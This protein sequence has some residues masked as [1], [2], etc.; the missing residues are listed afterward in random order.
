VVFNYRLGI[1]A[2]EPGKVHKL[3]SAVTPPINGASTGNLDLDQETAAGIQI[4]L[5]IVSTEPM[6]EVTEGQVLF[7]HGDHLGSA[8]IVTDDQGQV[9]ERISY[10]PYGLE[11]ARQQLRQVDVP[12]A[13]RFT[14]QEFEQEIGLYDYGARF[15]DHVVG[16]FISVDPMAFSVTTEQ[17]VNPGNL[18][19]Y[20]YAHNN[21]ILFIDPDGRQSYPAIKIHERLRLE[22]YVPQRLNKETGEKKVVGSSGVTIGYGYDIGTHSAAEVKR[23]M[24]AAGISKDIIDTY[25]TAAGI[26]KANAVKWLGDNP[27]APSITRAQADALFDVVIQQMERRAMRTLNKLFGEGNWGTWNGLTPGQRALLVDRQYNPSKPLERYNQ[28]FKDVINQDWDA[29]RQSG[30]RPGGAPGRNAWIMDTID[31]EAKANE[32]A[33]GE[34]SK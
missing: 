29:A 9:V 15:Y 12:V 22:P 31:A 8:S 25:V 10:Y 18:N 16:R 2:F 28:F 17:L 14:G 34:A 11:R 13:Y 7:Y 32:S 23:D 5:P 33:K 6:E 26:Q 21:P 20:A 30:P 24:A 4:W 19:Y 27:N 1:S 3:N